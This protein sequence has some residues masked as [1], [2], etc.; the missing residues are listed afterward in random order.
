VNVNEKKASNVSR[1]YACECKLGYRV[2]FEIIITRPIYRAYTYILICVLSTLLCRY[3]LM[4]LRIEKCAVFNYDT[5]AID[6]DRHRVTATDRQCNQTAWQAIS[7]ILSFL[8]SGPL[9]TPSSFW[10]FQIILL[11]YAVVVL[12]TH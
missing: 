8:W 1:S 3:L 10:Q 4:S 7:N 2:T 5:K 6:Y 12:F 9:R 11:N